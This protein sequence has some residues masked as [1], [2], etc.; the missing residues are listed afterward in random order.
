VMGYI[1]WTKSWSASDNG[2]IFGGSDLQNLQNDITTVINGGLTNSNV[3]SGAAIEESK[4]AFDTSAGHDHDGSNSKAISGF[5]HSMYGLE[6]VYKDAATITVKPGKC[7][8]GGSTATISADTDI[9]LGTGGNWIDGDSEGTSELIYV[10]IDSS[11][12]LRLSNSAP[13]I[14][15]TDDADV[16]DIK[17]YHEDS[18]SA[19]DYY[20]C[21][22]AMYNDSSGDL[23]SFCQQG[24]WMFLGKA[25]SYLVQ[26]DGAATTWTDV[27]C[28]GS[29]PAFSR[30]V[31]LNVKPNSGAVALSLK[32]N[33]V[34]SLGVEQQC[35]TATA[36]YAVPSPIPLDSSGI[37]EYKVSGN[38]I[39]IYV[40][41]YEI[42]GLRGK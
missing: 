4:I 10:Y 33:G 41:S 18:A 39:D 24:D 21:I 29:V 11:N 20:R 14:D 3:D 16:D 17:R 12:N 15:W 28:S 26:D 37:F 6:L 13:D 27:D 2:T 34:S 7:D 22:G 30:S 32:G 9:D 40:V 19:D 1:Q 23:V 35:A 31:V 25:Q 5:R 42:G 36:L 8:I 38:N